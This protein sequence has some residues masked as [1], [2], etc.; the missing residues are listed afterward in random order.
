MFKGAL[1]VHLAGAS[2][3]MC[4]LIITDYSQIC[5]TRHTSPEHACTMIVC[6]DDVHSIPMNDDVHSDGFRTWNGVS[7]SA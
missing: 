4:A 6:I 3:M 2:Q 7:M 1:H 5:V